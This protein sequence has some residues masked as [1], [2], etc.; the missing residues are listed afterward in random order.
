MITDKFGVTKAEYKA[1]E[2]EANRLTKM[3]YK[4]PSITI[5][6]IA[7]QG[8]STTNH[9]IIHPHLNIEYLKFVVRHE[10]GHQNDNQ[11]ELNIWANDPIADLEERMEEF[12]NDFANRT[13]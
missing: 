1:I 3:G 11:T 8:L 4:V 5:A 7:Y 13:K 6:A 2:G 10:I 12:A 9:I